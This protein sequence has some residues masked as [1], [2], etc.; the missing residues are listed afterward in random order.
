MCDIESSPDIMLPNAEILLVH[1]MDDQDCP[2]TSRLTRDKK[3]VPTSSWRLKSRGWFKYLHSE[4]LMIVTK[5][6]SEP[7]M[8][9]F[10]ASHECYVSEFDTEIH[11]SIQISRP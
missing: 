4:L 6:N 8:L 2:D 7:K 1:E 10:L 11:I 3:P 9:A 5:N